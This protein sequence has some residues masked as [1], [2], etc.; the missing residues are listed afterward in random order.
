MARYINT[1]QDDLASKTAELDSVKA[2]LKDLE[3]YLTSSKFHCG[4]DLDGYVNTQD[5]LNRLRS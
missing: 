5:V 2:K 4:D 1:L 3:S